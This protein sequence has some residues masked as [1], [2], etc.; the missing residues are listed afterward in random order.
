MCS[1]APLPSA[2]FQTSDGSGSGVV[3]RTS[4]PEAAVLANR[5][6]CVGVCR[7]RSARPVQTGGLRV[8]SPVVTDVLVVD[9]VLLYGIPGCLLACLC[10]RSNSRNSLDLK[11]G[12]LKSASVACQD[13]NW[14]SSLQPG[15][16]GQIC[17]SFQATP[18]RRIKRHRRS[19][20]HR[21]I[22]EGFSVRI[23]GL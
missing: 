2:V 12:G 3:E 11:S 19:I 9:V 7:E 13:S 6:R 16:Y 20:P 1:N 21:Q 17:A 5:F 18:L 22:S 10:T 15:M 23:M 4:I 8:F 14:T